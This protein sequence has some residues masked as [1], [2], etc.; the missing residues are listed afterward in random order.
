VIRSVLYLQP[1]DG[2]A[3][4]VAER[5][6]KN[7]VLQ[8]A[9]ALDGCLG[10]ELQLPIG[11]PGPVLVTALWRDPAAYQTW[12]DS[13]VRAAHGEEL[14]ELIDAAPGPGLHGTLYEIVLEAPA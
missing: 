1:R 13:P 10:A 4:A 2:N 8:D 14:A 9:A 3:E 6:E 5:Y 12:V 7:G 11:E